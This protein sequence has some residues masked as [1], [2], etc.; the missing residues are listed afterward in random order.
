VTAL[1]A[2][3]KPRPKAK[4]RPKSGVLADLRG[5]LLPPAVLAGVVVGFAVL[6]RPGA[7]PKEA[8]AEPF[9][10]V[11]IPE[12]DRARIDSWPKFFACYNLTS[13]Q[14]VMTATLRQAGFAA[15]PKWRAD[16]MIRVPLAPEP[17]TP[18]AE[19]AAVLQEA[20]RLAQQRA[21]AGSDPCARG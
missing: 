6:S 4:N 19:E 1:H 17:L 16:A 5:G 9:A 21:V 8:R 18:T 11:E 20:G 13:P 7:P 12:A 10:S 14:D 3:P 2:K 15:H